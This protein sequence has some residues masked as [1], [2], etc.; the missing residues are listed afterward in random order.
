VH[1]P[2]QG[3]LLFLRWRVLPVALNLLDLSYYVADI[4]HVRWS[5]VRFPEYTVEEI[6]IYIDQMGTVVRENQKGY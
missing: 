2:V 5:L 3:L 6:A 1:D 4:G